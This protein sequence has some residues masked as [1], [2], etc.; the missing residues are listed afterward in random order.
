MVKVKIKKGNNCL[1]FSF[2]DDD[3]ILEFLEKSVHGLRYLGYHDGYISDD[4]GMM[5]YQLFKERD[6]EIC[7]KDDMFSTEDVLKFTKTIISQYK[8]GNTNIE[9]IDLLTETLEK[10]KNSRKLSEKK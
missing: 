4:F 5:A 8:A 10:F 6:I 2:K 7:Y 3:S 1:N 9:N